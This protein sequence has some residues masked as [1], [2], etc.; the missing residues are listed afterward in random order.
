[1]QTIYPSKEDITALGM[2]Y[3]DYVEVESP[4]FVKEITTDNRDIA[5]LID[6]YD[7]IW[8][9]AIDESYAKRRGWNDLLAF[10]EILQNALV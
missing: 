7:L 8:T 3:L 5:K 9:L 2:R 6:H 1:M 4:E 10:R